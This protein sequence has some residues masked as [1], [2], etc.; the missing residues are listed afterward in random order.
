MQSPNFTF[1]HEQFPTQVGIKKKKKKMKAWNY[2]FVVIVS[3]LSLVSY[4]NIA[5]K[6]S[7]PHIKKKPLKHLNTFLHIS[8]IWWTIKSLMTNIPLNKRNL[9]MFIYVDEAPHLT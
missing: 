8:H 5:S 1:Y 6:A 7:N 3:C 9:I 4:Y 2:S